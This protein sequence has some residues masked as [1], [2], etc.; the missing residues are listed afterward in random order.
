[1]T[2]IVRSL[3]CALAFTTSLSAAMV[4]GRVDF[5]TKRGQHPIA[6]ETLVWLEPA[7]GT[8]AVRMAPGSFQ[9]VT[10]G[11]MLIPHVLAVPVGSTVTFPNDDP[12]SHNLF[13]LTS[14]NSFDL[15][16]YRRG[17]GKSQTFDTPGAVSVYCN[18]HPSMS[19]VIQVMDTPYYAFATPA[20]VFSIDEVPAGRYR[21]IAWN[22]QSG[23]VETP[24]EVTANGSV[25]GETSVTLD[26][27]NYRLT[28][29]L[30]KL[31]KPYKPPRD[32]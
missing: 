21:L 32:Y 6:E 12:I 26:S 17:S 22:E 14:A 15:G 11:K 18:V 7:V 3:A 16:L 4:A 9:M 10:R 28:Q 30:N 1:M 24:V 8:R 19:A 27:R 2:H 25:R 29:H 5:L 13:S 20:G 31:G 23:Q